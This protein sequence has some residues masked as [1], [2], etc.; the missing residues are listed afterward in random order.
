MDVK[1]YYGKVRE[2]EASLAAEHIVMVSLAT[3]EGGKEGVRTEVPRRVAATL[4]AEN[5]A[6]IASEEEAQ[7]FHETNCAAREK[8]EEDE[9]ARRMQVVVMPAREAKKQKERS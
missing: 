1:A 3:P 5:R 4:I 6:R 8:Y 9:A 2:A 7:A